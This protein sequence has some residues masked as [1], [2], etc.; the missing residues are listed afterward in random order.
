MRVMCVKALPNNQTQVET[1]SIDITKMFQESDKRF[2][3]NSS[4]ESSQV[5]LGKVS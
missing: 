5:L 4:L 3:Q 2:N 1:Q